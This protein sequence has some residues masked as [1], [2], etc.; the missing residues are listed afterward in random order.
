M[1]VLVRNVARLAH[2]EPTRVRCRSAAQ[3]RIYRKQV[4]DSELVEPT[5]QVSKPNSA[6]FGRRL[7][8]IPRDLLTKNRKYVLRWMWLS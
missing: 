3:W 2:A 5:L 8:R 1:I 6:W 4:F 7:P